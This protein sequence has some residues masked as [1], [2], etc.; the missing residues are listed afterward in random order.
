MKKNTVEA[1]AASIF[2]NAAAYIRENGWQKEGM[3]EEG[4]PR[5]SMGALETAGP[6][7]AE[8]DENLSKLMY[9]SL[10]EELN[11]ISLTSFN[12]KYQSG[13]KVAQLYESVASKLAAGRFQ[14][15][16]FA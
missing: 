10:Y 5:C 13:E 6:S 1:Q 3:G 11:G 2:F 7:R 8:W 12:S 15:G 4:A 16:K 14:I 9:D